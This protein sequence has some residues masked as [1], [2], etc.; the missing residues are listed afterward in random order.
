MMPRKS[1]QIIALAILLG[2]SVP[3]AWEDGCTPFIQAA[4]DAG[5]IIRARLTM[6]ENSAVGLEVVEDVFGKDLPKRVLISK[7]LWDVWGPKG[8]PVEGVTYL[9][10]LRQGEELLCGH[11]NGLILLDHSCNGILPV[12]EGA[13]PKEFGKQYDGASVQA[14]PLAKVRDQIRSIEK[15]RR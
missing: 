1:L 5:G 11:I 15:A 9:V 10:L 8:L 14:I 4:V 7:S 3:L 2:S 6:A 13:I 12:V